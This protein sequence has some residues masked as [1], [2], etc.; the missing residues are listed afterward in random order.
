MAQLGR[1]LIEVELV[2]PAL[3]DRAEGDP[4]AFLELAIEGWIKEAGAD[5]IEKLGV[6]AQLSS[7]VD[8]LFDFDSGEV[9][10]IDRMYLAFV[11]TYWYQTVEMADVVDLLG[12]VHPRLPRTFQVWFLDALRS[13]ADVWG[14]DETRE[15][16]D[17][18][19]GYV[20]ET[21]MLAIEEGEEPPW[22][23]EITGEYEFRVDIDHPALTKKP[24]AESTVRK[25][26]RLM[27]ARV[28]RI[29]D[30]TI[31]IRKAA[32]EVPERYPEGFFSEKVGVEFQ[33]PPPLLVLPNEQGDVIERVWDEDNW[34]RGEVGGAAAPYVVLPFHPLDDE[35]LQRVHRDFVA[36]ARVFALA[37][38][39]Y[40]LLPREAP[41]SLSETLR[42]VDE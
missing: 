12:T 8:L 13:V 6:A 28:R 21:A 31:E 9:P 42:E 25:L 33:Y 17:M 27:P 22:P 32:Q 24:L 19:S 23:I 20:Y 38:R 7:D 30:L 39:I 18:C 4:E 34:Q 3:W 2:D 29:M 11:S 36:V 40:S 10:T 16:L 5:V 14:V 35:D 26:R 41:S 1:R 37:E 15:W